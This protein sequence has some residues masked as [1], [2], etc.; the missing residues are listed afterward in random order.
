MNPT[1]ALLALWSVGALLTAASLH[2]GSIVKQSSIPFAWFLIGIGAWPVVWA[3]TIHQR[4]RHKALV[5]QR[6]VEL[7]RPYR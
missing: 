7:A 6:L 5:R 4:A 2:R 1:F 3:M